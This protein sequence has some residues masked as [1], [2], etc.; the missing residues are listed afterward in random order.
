MHKFTSRKNVRHDPSLQFCTVK[1]RQK[2]SEHS[3]K[4]V[5]SSRKLDKVIK[6]YLDSK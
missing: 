6:R 2:Q 3:R 1:T 5:T 4:F